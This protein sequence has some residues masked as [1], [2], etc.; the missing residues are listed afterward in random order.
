MTQL[1]NVMVDVETLGLQANACILSIGACVF[2]PVRGIGNE[3]Y[4]EVDMHSQCG[5]IDV[6]TLQFWFKQT[7]KGTTPP[8]FGIHDMAQALI[9]LNTWLLRVSNNNP[10]NLRIWANGTDFDIPKLYWQMDQFK[11]ES[12]WKY[13]QV[14]DARTIYKLFGGKDLEPT[15]NAAKHNALED[16]KWQSQYLI[17]LYNNGI[18]LK[19]LHYVPSNLKAD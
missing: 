17:N 4:L 13:S 15:P 19:E 10:E 8:V 3:F 1:V 5:G 7:E 2:C 11:I 12:V 18:V 6:S 16:C 9:G 14:R